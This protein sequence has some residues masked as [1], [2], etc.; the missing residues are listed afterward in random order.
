ML[1][2]GE[3]IAEEPEN[4]DEKTVKKVWE[5]NDNLF[6]VFEMKDK[7][8]YPGSFDPLTFGHLDIIK[9]ASG[10]FDEVHVALLNNTS[11]NT[12]FLWTKD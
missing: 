2:S 3:P 9:R 12:C 7:C 11:K 1:E 4:F 8:V 10:L 6:G 5:N